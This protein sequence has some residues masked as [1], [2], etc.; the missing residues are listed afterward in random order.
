M[1]ELY[2][3]DSF[4]NQI[5]PE[6]LLYAFIESVS[7]DIMSAIYKDIVLSGEMPYEEGLSKQEQ[8]EQ[9]LNEYGNS[10]EDVIERIEIELNK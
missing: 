4:I 8:V 1:S 3:I 10:Y 7:E 9:I 5:E 2:D 6:K